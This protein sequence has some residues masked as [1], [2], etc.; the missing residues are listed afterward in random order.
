MGSI[1]DGHTRAVPA[2]IFEEA[3]QNRF[4]VDVTWFDDGLF[5]TR[6]AQGTQDA[7]EALG[8]QLVAVGDVPVEEMVTRVSSALSFDNGNLYD[9]HSTFERFIVRPLLLHAA[10][11]TPDEQAAVFTFVKEGVNNGE[12][13]TLVL[14]G[15]D[16]TVDLVGPDFTDPPL[17]WQGSIDSAVVR[18]SYLEDEGAVYLQYSDSLGLGLDFIDASTRALQLARREGVDKL[19]VDVRYNPGGSELPF[20]IFNSRL[21]Q[22]PFL[23]NG[24]EVYVIMSRYTFSAGFD[25]VS[26]LVNAHGAITVGQPPGRAPTSLATSRSLPYRTRVL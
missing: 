22:H 11:L 25:V 8:A 17:Y 26:G 16:E 6:A 13:F 12:P 18:T 2:G 9:Q 4:P 23:Q 5:V 20:L 21:G 10:G 1:G 24:G 3:Y 14:E 19:I 7:Q 15:Q